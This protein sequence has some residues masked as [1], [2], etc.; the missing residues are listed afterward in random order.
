MK[1]KQLIFR[2]V[3]SHYWTVS[4]F[5]SFPFDTIHISYYYKEATIVIMDVTR[6]KSRLRLSFFVIIKEE[7]LRKTPTSMRKWMNKKATSSFKLHKR[8]QRRKLLKSLFVRIT[9][10]QMSNLAKKRKGK[11]LENGA[12]IDLISFMLSVLPPLFARKSRFCKWLFGD[13]WS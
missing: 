7:G 9:H 1:W 12:F 10:I 13:I 8:R 4:I 11:S 6:K 3:I 5:L 2:P